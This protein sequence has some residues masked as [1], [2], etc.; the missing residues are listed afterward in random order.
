MQGAA[1]LVGQLAAQVVVLLP[2]SQLPSLGIAPPAPEAAA[3]APAVFPAVPELVAP[4]PAAGGRTPPEPAV[5]APLPAAP[6]AEPALAPALPASAFA[7]PP[8][9][10]PFRWLS[11]PLQ[12][13]DALRID[14]SNPLFHV[15]LHRAIATFKWAF[16]P[17]TGQQT[18][19]RRACAQA[20]S[21]M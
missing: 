3:P 6:P 10:L 1:K 16:A 21:G 14:K 17:A 9:A 19:A 12:A 20:A 5:M 15:G 11:S 2:G 18:P 4:P 7:R 13:N 8:A